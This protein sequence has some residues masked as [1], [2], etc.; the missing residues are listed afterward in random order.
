MPQKDLV[1]VL[2]YLNAKGKKKVHKIGLS[3]FLIYIPYFISNGG[4]EAEEENK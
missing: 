3:S 1:E 2:Y 4:K